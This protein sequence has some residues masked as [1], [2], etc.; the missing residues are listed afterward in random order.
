MRYRRLRTPFGTL[1]TVLLIGGVLA[2]RLAA[3]EA[4]PGPIT[5]IELAPGVIAEVYAG[6]P[7]ARAGADRLPGP[8][9]LPA[10]SLARLAHSAVATLVRHPRRAGLCPT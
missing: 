4:T 8:L 10:G 6:A 1:V 7:S 5:A 9:R 2:P 3:Q